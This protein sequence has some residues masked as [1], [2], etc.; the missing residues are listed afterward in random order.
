MQGVAAFTLTEMVWLDNP[1][2]S[3]SDVA[4]A[5]QELIRQM[6]D[7]GATIQAN[8]VTCTSAAVS[9][10]TNH[11][12][13]VVVT[14]TK[15]GDGLIQQLIIPEAENLVC[16]ADGQ[17]G[18]GAVP[19]NEQFQWAGEQAAG[20]PWDYQFP[21]GS[22]STTTLI[23]VN[24][25]VDNDG[26]N[27]LV[28]SSFETWTTANIPDNWGLTGGAVAG[29]NVKQS[30]SVSFV[31]T[32]SLQLV[33]DGATLAG[34]QQTFNISPTPTPGAGGTSYAPP[35]LSQ[36]AFSVWVQVDVTPST[37]TLEIALVDGSG[38][39]IQD[40][41]GV[42]NV[43]TQSL[44][45]L[46]G[47]VWTNING[48]FRTPNLLPTTIKL[49]IRQSVAI[50]SGKSAFVDLMGFTQMTQLYTGGPSVSI[51]AGSVN[52]ITG[53]VAYNTADQ[54]RLT[55]TNNFG[56]ASNLATFSWTIQR[57]LDTASMGLIIPYSNA[58]S[59]PDS[60]I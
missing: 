60:L 41:Q 59:I 16:T 44:T 57:F 37:G 40:Q 26:N 17:T 2:S 33:G 6:E 38:T 7:S 9:G 43:V 29:V 54:F 14:S 10:V 3:R 23:T 8:T 13:G 56:G 48:V 18:G 19:G 36:F 47:G 51:F 52:F 53:S 11:G 30:T 12:N 55:M 20:G 31:G 45:G 24:G 32:S 21:L 50:E 5:M 25:A 28:N 35:P 27:L 34:V 42:N 1:L 39:V 58:P 15:R 22:G 4:L 49:R 46:T